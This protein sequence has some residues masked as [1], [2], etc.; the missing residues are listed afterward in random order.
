MIKLR[1]DY[2]NTEKLTA[3]YLKGLKVYAFEGIPEKGSVIEVEGKKYRVS[4][5]LYLVE[6]LDEPPLLIVEDIKS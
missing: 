5:K 2:M 4:E 1:L 3:S 6:S